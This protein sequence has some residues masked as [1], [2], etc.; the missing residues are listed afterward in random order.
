MFTDGADNT[1][2]LTEA[3]VIDVGKHTDAVVYG[4]YVRRTTTARGG[5]TVRDEHGFLLSDPF[6][7][8]LTTV[9]T[10][11]T[12][13]LLRDLAEETGGR[14]IEAE[15]DADLRGCTSTLDEFRNRYVLSYTPTGVSATGWH[16]LDVKLKGKRG[17][18]TARRGYFAP[19]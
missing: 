6:E 2:W 14:L 12:P 9:V 18:V 10:L 7:M 1:S 5:D 15:R 17:K 11:N 4:V 19:E 13:G 3:N 16:A 8:T